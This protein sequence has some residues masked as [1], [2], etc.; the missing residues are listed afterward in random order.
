LWKKIFVL[1]IK[2]SSEISQKNI[3]R[4]NS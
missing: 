2:F 4:H 1:P 3:Y